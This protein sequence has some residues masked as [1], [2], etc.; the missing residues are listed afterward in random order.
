MSAREAL[1]FLTSSPY[2]PRLIARLAEGPAGPAALVDALGCSRTSVHRHLSALVERGWVAKEEGVYRLTTAGRHVNRSYADCA[3]ALDCV[4]E[5]EPLLAALPAFD[6]PLDAGLLAGG[7]LAVAADDTPH[8]PVEQ[9]VT[10]LR[11][12]IGATDRLRC[13]TPVLSGVFEM[14]HREAIE[15][16]VGTELLLPAS[17]LE[18]ARAADPEEVRRD[19]RRP[20]V[21]VATLPDCPGFGLAVAD[22]AAFLGGYD[23]EG[24]MVAGFGSGSREFRAWATEVYE[25]LAGRAETVGPDRDLARADG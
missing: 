7:T 18:Q 20:E 6:P 24:R 15:A 16:G 1:E 14:P 13:V 4:R 8:A 25:G 9:Y 21:T 2:R 22:S 3:T 17:L 12:R 5:Y 19:L 11:E 10:W 23:A